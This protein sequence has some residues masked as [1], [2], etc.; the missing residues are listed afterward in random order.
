MDKKRR[1][2][3]VTVVGFCGLLIVLLGGCSSPV[4]PWAAAPGEPRVLT[5][6]P[7][8]D[9]F[10]RNV[11]GEGVGVLCLI[12]DGPHEYKDPTSADILTVR[13]AD[14]FLLNG[15]GLETKKAMDAL[16]NN[17]GNVRLAMIPVGEAVPKKSRRSLGEHEREHEKDHKHAKGEDHHHE[18]NE[19][20]HV[21]LGIPEAK[22]L[23]EKIRD[24]LQR[25]D[26]KRKEQYAANAKNY[27]ARLDALKE[28]GEQKLGKKGLKV[29]AMHDSM[30]YFAR[31]FHI[32]VVANIQVEPGEDPSARKM[33]ELT[34]V[35]AEKKVQ[36]VCYEKKGAKA[37]AETLLDSLKSK[38]VAAVLV[39]FDPLETAEPDQLNAGWYEE[40]M[41]ANIDNLAKALK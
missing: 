20:P 5:S 35:G 11:A 32:D 36:A 1:W 33:L 7:P 27:L 9:C 24:E 16:K 3:R 12:T 34:Q 17:S 15:L 39:E 37:P 40:R 13:K 41:R 14:L 10:T 30:G 38:G 23:V 8:I 28:Y 4:N 6:F 18:G 19:D 2:T 29:I 26:P 25:I 21:W 22:L 31:A